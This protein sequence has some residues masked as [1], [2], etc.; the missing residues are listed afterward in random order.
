MATRAKSRGSNRPVRTPVSGRRDVMTVAN[1]D[2]A[3]VYRWVN[4]TQGRIDLFLKGGY[5]F[6]QEDLAVGDKSVDST[7]DISSMVSKG[8][9]GGTTAY[10]MRISKEFYEEDR[11]AANRAIDE[12]EADMKRTLNSGKDGT[13][14]SVKIS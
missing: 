9:G 2:E 12:N 7:S 10:L 11:A 1:T 13:Y 3:F 4:D 14:G 8:V 5:E 6:V